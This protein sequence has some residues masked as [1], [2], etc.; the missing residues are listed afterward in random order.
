MIYVDQRR[1]YRSGHR[2]CSIQKVGLK[3]FSKFTGKHQC[4]SLFFN[5]VVGLKA[6]N[7]IKKES[8]VQVFCC[9]V[10]EIFRNSFLTEHVRATV[11]VLRAL[12]NICGG[13]FL[14][15]QS[16]AESKIK[17]VTCSKLS[18]CALTIFTGN[19]EA[20]QYKNL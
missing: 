1:I 3:N 19:T 2:R 18:H 5:K 20:I 6:C 15:K 16:T 7:Y 10:S 11:S 8:L 14:Q 17:E 9:E 12:T 13:V 4:H